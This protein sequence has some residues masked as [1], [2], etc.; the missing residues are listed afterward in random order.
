MGSQDTRASFPENR[1]TKAPRPVS[2]RRSWP[3][4][5]PHFV[6]TP[7]SPPLLRNALGLDT[8]RLRDPART[9]VGHETVALVLGHQ[10]EGANGREPTG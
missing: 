8:V 1:R 4:S 5:S 7:S 2:Q 9:K 3:Q 10:Q 6:P